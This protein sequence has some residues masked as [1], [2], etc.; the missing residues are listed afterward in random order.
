MDLSQSKERRVPKYWTVFVHYRD[1]ILSGEY[2]S[3]MRLPS[4]NEV[5]KLFGISRP[6]VNHAFGQL[7]QMRLVIRRVGSG[8]YVANPEKNVSSSD[9]SSAPSLKTNTLGLLVPGLGQGEIFEPICNQ[10]VFTSQENGFRVFVGNT[11]ALRGKDDMAR[12]PFAEELCH[13]CIDQKV[14]GVFFQPLELS[15]GAEEVNRRILDSL[16]TAGIPVVLIDCDYLSFPRR[17]D[18]DLVGIDN[19]RVGYTLTEH[20]LETGVKNIHFIARQGS[21]P[22]IK[23]RFAGFREALL[24]HNLP[25]DD[26]RFHSVSDYE[27]EISQLMSM[28]PRPDAFVCG[29]DHTA[30]LVIQVLGH[31]NVRIPQDVRITGVD[32]LRYAT[33]ISVPLTTISQ[34]CEEMGRQAVRAM[35]E[36]IKTPNLPTRDFFVNFKLIVRN[37]SGAT[38]TAH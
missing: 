27:T 10:I 4:E 12:G 32:N 11:V 22:S 17:S 18:F 36:R 9:I 2:P 19:F 38:P 8:T 30:A 14:D 23:I 28:R 24:S 15:A 7:E 37:S 6:T 5:A 26:N 34:P 31:L 13:Q 29:N 21:A 20:L 16:K 25:I 1:G 35:M 33:L 3:G